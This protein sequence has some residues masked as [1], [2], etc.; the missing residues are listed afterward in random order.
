MP[1]DGGAPL[2]QVDVADVAAYIWALS[3]HER[4]HATN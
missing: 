2:S 4:K 3:H 1:P